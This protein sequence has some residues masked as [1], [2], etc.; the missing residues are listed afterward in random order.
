MALVLISTLPWVET[1]FHGIDRAAIWHRRLAIVGLFLLI[2]HILLASNEDA[3]QFGPLLATIGGS[4]LAAL[5]VWAVLPRWRSILPGIAVAPV[6]AISESLIGSGVRR[7]LGNYERWRAL[8]R[9]TGLFVAAAFI[10]GLLDA[11]AFSQS[12][13]LRWSFV[14]I[15]GVGLTFYIYRELFARLFWPFHDYQIK[16]LTELGD[17]LVEVSL[18]PLGQPLQ[19]TPGQFVLLYVESKDGWQ[20][21]PFT[22]SSAP[23]DNLIRFTVKA[24]GDF[25]TN[26]HKTL[27]PGM[28]AVI[29]SPHGRF[30]W[31]T[32]T[33]SQVWIGAG[34][35]VT[36]FLSWIRSLD[37]TLDE[38]VDFYYL[39]RGEG[40]FAA[41]IR[42]IEE[43]FPSLNVHFIDT[44]AHGHMT[45]E[46]VLD[47][48]A[49]P[50]DL[51][52]VYMCGPEKMI[53][54]F[55]ATFR[56]AGI[57]RSHIHHEYFNIR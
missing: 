31:R 2:P 52:S 39:S 22:I 23:S 12:P 48:I 1:W 57:W 49:V 11:T 46:Q 7:L 36:P 40:P 19:F 50:M 30:D 53:E 43:R 45:P 44:K 28:P 9:L 29:G 17:G 14:I 33:N 51:V 27:Q 32:G 18:V 42:G 54:Q 3:S 47:H 26:I 5:G 15:G 56:S 25:T 24:L 55:K 8:H 34:V 6:L 20:R 13:T 10:H 4:G 38:T 37:G 16:D 41:E 21:H 35:G